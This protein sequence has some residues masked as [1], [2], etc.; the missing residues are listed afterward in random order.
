MRMIRSASLVVMILAGVAFAGCG[1]GGG[2]TV[3]PPVDPLDA[4]W[5]AFESGD[6]VAARASFHEALAITPGNTEAMNGLGWTLAHLDSLPAALAQLTICIAADP[7]LAE[8]Q[9]GRAAVARDIPDFALAIASADAA[10]AIAPRFQFIHEPDVDWQDLRLIIAQVAYA[11]ADYDRCLA[12][13]D[14][15]DGNRPDPASPTFAAE[16]LAELERLGG[17]FN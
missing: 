10:L 8:A 6:Y 5:A 14:S 12:E 13:V 9:A 2:G 3:A 16:L 11:T 17:L 4:A 1:G 7:G 15:L